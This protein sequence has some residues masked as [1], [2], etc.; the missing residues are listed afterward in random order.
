MKIANLFRH[1]QT[2]LAV[3][4]I[5]ALCLS[6]A[7]CERERRSFATADAATA[8]V[9]AEG[10]YETN[11]YGISQGQ[12]LY[13]YFNCGGCH[14]HGGGGMGPALMDD[15]WRYGSAPVQI[16]SS[17]ADGRPNGMPAF[18]GRIPEDQLWQLTAYV[19]SL[20]GLA[21]QDGAPNRDDALL[22]RTPESFSD[23]QQPEPAQEQR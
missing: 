3:V 19:R 2:T 14:S 11:A 18:R 13:S 4:L 21:P 6:G 1:P 12:Q 7:G 20:S 17:I 22:T 5:M 15:Q 8:A 9:P 23:K 16:Y 10:P